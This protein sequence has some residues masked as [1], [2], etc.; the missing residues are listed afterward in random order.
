MNPYFLHESNIMKYLRNEPLFCRC[1][2]VTAIL[3]GIRLFA[4][5]LGIKFLIFLLKIVPVIFRL[6]LKPASKI[7]R[8]NYNLLFSSHLSFQQLKPGG[9]IFFSVYINVLALIPT[10]ISLYPLILIANVCSMRP[11]LCPLKEWSTV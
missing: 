10:G 6:G 7:P 3:T 8:W 11:S 4:M 2:S 1:L 9:I 5:S